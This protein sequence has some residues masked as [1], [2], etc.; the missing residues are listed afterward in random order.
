MCGCVGVLVAATAELRRCSSLRELHL[1]FNRLVTPLLDLTHATALESLQVGALWGVVVGTSTEAQWADM[2]PVVNSSG[3]WQQP[4]L[5]DG[6]VSGSLNSHMYTP[7]GPR[8]IQ[9]L[10]LQCWR[11]TCGG[12][13]VLH[14]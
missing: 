9:G 5:T 7:A 6:V 10:D 2:K 11:H 4:F 3:V 12:V 1:E 14:Y 13:V 8:H